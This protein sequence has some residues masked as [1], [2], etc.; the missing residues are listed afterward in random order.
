MKRDREISLTSAVS[1]DPSTKTT[2]LSEFETEFYDIADTLLNHTIL[3]LNGKIYRLAEVEAYLKDDAHYDTFTHC[4]EQQLKPG[5]W[6]FHKVGKGYK[7]GSYKGLDVTFSKRGYSGMLIRAI[8]EVATNKYIEGPSLVVDQILRETGASDIEALTKKE[9]FKWGALEK[10]LCYLR[11]DEDK[12]L[13]IRPIVQ[14]P[15]VGLVLRTDNHSKFLMKPYRFMTFPLLCKKGKQHL[16]LELYYS[17]KTKEEIVKITAGTNASVTGYIKSFEE[18]KAKPKKAK[19]YYAQKLKT[20]EFS[21]CFQVL[22]LEAAN[23][24]NSTDDK[25]EE[26]K[27][28]KEEEEEV[29]KSDD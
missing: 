26:K 5:E 9:D 2:S 17:G 6:Y 19:E 28:K 13:E 11:A 7:G 22:R 4:D 14:S 16:V 10:S 12:K 25:K 29:S 15:R 23:A 1:L 21:K 24:I 27:E 18:S 8:L 20:E 3:D